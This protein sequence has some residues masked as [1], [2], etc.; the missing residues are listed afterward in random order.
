MNSN[1]Q[2]SDIESPAVGALITWP[3][4]YKLLTD[5]YF[6]GRAGS[7][8]REL[9]AASGL[10][11]GESALDI[12]CGPGRLVTELARLAG[13]HGRAVGLDPSAEMIDYAAAHAAPNCSFDLGAAQSLPY[14]D[15]SFDVV[16]STFAMH[17]IAEAERKTALEAMFRVLRPGGRLLLADTHPATAGL[18]GLLIRAMARLAAHRA[19]NDGHDHGAGGQH[20]HGGESLST[21]DVRRYRSALADLGFTAIAFRVGPYAT[22]ILTAVKPD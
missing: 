14:P 16:T 17:H 12:G 18:R 20:E 4:R 13:P 6:L 15:A 8:T 19:G 5:V 9:A 2:V 22:G 21:V 7:L 1:R 10:G 11:P 3:R